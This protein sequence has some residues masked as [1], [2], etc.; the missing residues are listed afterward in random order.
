MPDLSDEDILA[1]LGLEAEPPTPVVRNPREERIIAGF[2]D[3]QQFVDQHGHPPRHGEDHDIFERLYAVRLDRLRKLDDCRTLLE[4]LD[5]QGLLSG[6]STDQPPSDV[7]DDELLAALG[8]DG[9]EQ[10]DLTK[11]KHVRSSA[12]KK[13]AEEVAQREPCPD[14]QKF[15]PVF[16]QVQRELDSGLRTTRPFQLKS[17]IRPGRFFI[18]GGQKAYVAEMEDIF[19]NAQGRTDAR[20]RVIF[21]N[22]TQSGM[23]MRSLQ[24]AL[25][26]DDASRRI[27][28]PSAGPLF[29][30][31][32]EE[33]DEESGTIYVLR[34]MSDLP[35]VTENRD[36]LHKVGVTG[37][38]VE[39]RI[40]NAK[41]EATY[42]LAD[43]EIVS[44]Y[45]LMNIDRNKLETLL[46]RVLEPARLDIEIEDRFGH[47]YRPKEWFLVPLFVIDDAVEKI[48]DGTIKRY[49][50]D[51]NQAKL[52]ERSV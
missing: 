7:S 43:V 41:V 33:G 31:D 3:I 13:A 48:K 14:F 6:V 9:Q 2:E 37:G 25:H 30:S 27:T 26:N 11:L 36:L 5:H 8:V 12:E 39:R 21:D 24:R 51:P 10:S 50:Y 47:P 15:K 35:I 4:P 16:D 32:V 52:V 29:S 1:S 18:V 34:S 20:M 46:H 45:K 28:D 23:L 22:G 42:L 49:V 38:S 19:T 44:T 40:A 17:E